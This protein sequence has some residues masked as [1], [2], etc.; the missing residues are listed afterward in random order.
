MYWDVQ[1][2]EKLTIL[3]PQPDDIVQ[4]GTVWIHGAA[5]VSDD[6]PLQIELFNRMDELIGSAEAR[7]QSDT[8]GVL[9]FF[10]AQVEYQVD[11]EQLCRIH[12][13]EPGGAIP[14]IRHLNSIHVH[15]K[16]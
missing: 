13:Y 14:G 12:V 5:W 4:G 1:G 9:G 2:A 8:T 7:V 16:P 15:L 10:E 3:S 11:F 6:V